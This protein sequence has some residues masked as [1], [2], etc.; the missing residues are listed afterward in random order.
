MTAMRMPVFCLVVKKRHNILLSFVSSLFR[1]ATLFS[2]MHDMYHQQ[3]NKWYPQRC[4]LAHI[5]ATLDF[6]RSE[7]SFEMGKWTSLGVSFILLLIVYEIVSVYLYVHTHSSDSEYLLFISI[8]LIHE[9]MD[10]N[11][12]KFNLNYIST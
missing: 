4:L 5:E 11:L 6:S 1:V 10:Q 3:Q 9:Q 8:K 12:N 7:C 2:H